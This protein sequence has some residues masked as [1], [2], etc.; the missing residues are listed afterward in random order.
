M[1]QTCVNVL[2]IRQNDQDCWHL[3]RQFERRGWHCWFADSLDGVQSLLDER[4]FHLVLSTRRRV[5]IQALMA[6]L[7]GSDCTL[8][9]SYP[10]EDSCLWLQPMRHGQECIP[11]PVLRPSEFMSSLDELV[12]S[13]MRR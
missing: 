11:T 9:Y 5:R 2:L 8:F 3:V 7:Q 6:L 12:M 4:S 10:I 13:L 1:E